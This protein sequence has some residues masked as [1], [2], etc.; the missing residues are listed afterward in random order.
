MPVPRKRNFRSA[1]WRVLPTSVGSFPSL[2][3][4]RPSEGE[5]NQLPAQFVRGCRS[6]EGRA[7]AYIAL[8]SQEANRC[9]VYFT[10]CCLHL[11]TMSRPLKRSWNLPAGLSDTE[12]KKIEVSCCGN[13]FSDHRQC[14]VSCLPPTRQLCH[15][16]RRPEPS[17]GIFGV[18][19]GQRD[20]VDW[21]LLPSRL[22]FSLPFR[23]C[24]ARSK[25]F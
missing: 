13:D 11:R 4:V 15:R 19:C 8:V 6:S 1:W 9:A 24:D 14:L 23:P 16:K 20:S 7:Q 25:S 3:R 22:S 18:P 21:E 12:M 2:P 17:S 5:V 10:M